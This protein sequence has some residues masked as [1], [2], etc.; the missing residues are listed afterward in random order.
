MKSVLIVD[1]QPGIRLLLEELLQREGYE[2]SSAANGHQA[3]EKMKNK[4]PDCVLLDMKMAGMDGTEVLT[5]IMNSWPEIPVFMMTGHGELEL[6]EKVLEIG[7]LR[8]FT[9]PFDIFEVRDAV[10]DLFTGQQLR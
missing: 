6:M 8:Y 1:D 7:A 3:L 5:E 2:A 9:K 4:Q 10:N